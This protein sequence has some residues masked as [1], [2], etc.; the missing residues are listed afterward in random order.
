M[1]LRL[2]LAFLALCL[3][4]CATVQ[5]YE[6]EHLSRPGMDTAREGNADRFYS[7]VRESR[8]GALPDSD[9]P[10]GGCGCN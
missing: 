4:A 1:T 7:H 5:P 10:G 8:E 2:L 3:S 6:R 9:T